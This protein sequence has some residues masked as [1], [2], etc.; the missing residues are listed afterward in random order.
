MMPIAFNPIHEPIMDGT[1]GRIIQN[2]T[3]ISYQFLMNFVI[4]LENF[5]RMK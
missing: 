3:D 2:I 4:N 5:V 1:H